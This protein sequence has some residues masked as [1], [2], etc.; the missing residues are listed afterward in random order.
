MD[1][2]PWCTIF[3]IRVCLW[4]REGSR[5][6]LFVGAGVHGFHGACV[7]ICIFVPL[8]GRLSETL[9]NTSFILFLKI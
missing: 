3:V 6:W 2:G 7:N 9:I 1:V 5:V 8:C 4:M